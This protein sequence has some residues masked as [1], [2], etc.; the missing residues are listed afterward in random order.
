MVDSQDVEGSVSAPCPIYPLLRGHWS[1]KSA[2]PQGVLL[3]MTKQ[4]TRSVG[5]RWLEAD[6]LEEETNRVRA[7]CS[8]STA[9][10][11]RIGRAAPM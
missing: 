8:L 6:S 9:V 2:E 1:T 10:D 3:L 7:L 11:V 4:L 5:C